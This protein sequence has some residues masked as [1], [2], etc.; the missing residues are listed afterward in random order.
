MADHID[1]EYFPF[2]L[3][4]QKVSLPILEHL[5]RVDESSAVAYVDKLPEGFL[6]V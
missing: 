6:W 1:L 3:S 2:A 5:H 4:F